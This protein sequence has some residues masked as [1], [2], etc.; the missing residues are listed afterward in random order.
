MRKLVLEKISLKP[1]VYHLQIYQL[2]KIVT[3]TSIPTE[4]KSVLE[5]VLIH[6]IY[7]KCNKMSD[8]LK[9]KTPTPLLDYAGIPFEYQSK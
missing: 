1:T 9:I 6:H 3:I 7:E 2:G 5:Y 8:W 4:D